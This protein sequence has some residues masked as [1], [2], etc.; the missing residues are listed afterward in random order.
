VRL[1]YVP[2]HARPHGVRVALKNSL[3]FGGETAVLPLRHPEEVL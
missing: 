2:N 1:D 3:A